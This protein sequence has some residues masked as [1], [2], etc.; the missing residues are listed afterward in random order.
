MNAVNQRVSDIQNSSFKIK[1]IVNIYHLI[2]SQTLRVILHFIFD[3]FIIHHL[4]F[5]V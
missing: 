4:Y 1:S 5:I 2:L 3:E